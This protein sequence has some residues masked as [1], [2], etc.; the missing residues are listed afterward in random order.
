[1]MET[2]EVIN[3]TIVI[4]NSSLPLPLRSLE[5]LSWN[6]WWS[7][8]AGGTSIFRDLDPDVWEECEHNPRQLLARTGEYRLMQMA[9]DSIYI[10]RVSM[11]SERFL[12]YMA[13]PL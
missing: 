4:D 3:E 13:R 5:Q 6:Y 7:W 10:E 11:L 8:S 12:Q 9:T 1:M 2:T